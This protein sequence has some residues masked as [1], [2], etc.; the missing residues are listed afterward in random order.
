MLPIES[1]LFKSVYNRIPYTS[2]FTLYAC[3]LE[4]YDL[5]STLTCLDLYDRLLFYEISQGIGI[6]RSPN[7]YYARG[8]K[9]FTLIEHRSYTRNTTIYYK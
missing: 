2:K 8:R 4:N 1:N 3:Y 6:T 7:K 5:F 9:G